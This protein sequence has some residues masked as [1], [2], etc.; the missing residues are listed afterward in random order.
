MYR[1]MPKHKLDKRKGLGMEGVTIMSKV[2][3][4]IQ[5]QKHL[6]QTMKWYL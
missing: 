1:R 3:L 4:T 5:K 6:L 2:T